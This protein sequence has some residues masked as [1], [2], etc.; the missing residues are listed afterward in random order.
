MFTCLEVAAD[1]FQL[2]VFYCQK[3]NRKNDKLDSTALQITV[4]YLFMGEL[5]KVCIFT[6]IFLFCEAPFHSWSFP[7]HILHIIDLFK[8]Q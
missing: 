5:E 2:P 1:H 3:C 4:F 8:E 6:I 7:L